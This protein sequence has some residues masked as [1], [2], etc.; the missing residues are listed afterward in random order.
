MHKPVGIGGQHKEVYK[1]GILRDLDVAIGV[2]HMLEARYCN[3][4][5]HQNPAIH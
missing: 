3:S 1:L 4:A 5:R 2:I